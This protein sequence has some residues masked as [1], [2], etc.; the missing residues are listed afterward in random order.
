MNK[1]SIH[2][3]PG[4]AFTHTPAQ[5]VLLHNCGDVVGPRTRYLA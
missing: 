2:C 3:E 1:F 4:L 5:N